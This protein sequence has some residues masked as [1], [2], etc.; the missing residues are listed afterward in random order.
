MR[1]CAQRRA[2]KPWGQHDGL[3]SLL[4]LSW[5]LQLLFGSA[6]CNFRKGL[7]ERMMRYQRTDPSHLQ[8]RVSRVQ[9]ALHFTELSCLLC[10]SL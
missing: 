10:L 7:C 3:C 8:A 9:H 1:Y 4:Q 5:L 6:S 2:K